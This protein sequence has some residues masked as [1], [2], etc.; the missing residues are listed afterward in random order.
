MQ[1]EYPN[2]SERQPEPQPAPSAESG[3]AQVEI[4]ALKDQ[5]LRARA[6]ME[7][8]RR[9]TERDRQ[10]AEKYAIARFARDLL[11]VADNFSR[12]L[13]AAPDEEGMSEAMRTFI[14]GVQMTEKEL[15]S[16]LERHGVRRIDPLGQPFDPNHHQAMFEMETQDYPAGHVAQVIAAGYLIG[17]RLLRP[18]M[19]GV[20]KSPQAEA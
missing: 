17:D 11:G 7:N 3:D 14:V 1:N 9:R 18:A 15:Q 19:V 5:L 10:E 4:E 13:G 16:T 20:A 6:D 8:L 12:A 2:D